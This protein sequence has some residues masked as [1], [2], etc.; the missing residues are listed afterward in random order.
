M[1]SAPASNASQVEDDDLP[2][3]GREQLCE[4]ARERLDLTSSQVSGELHQ[5][6]A[7]EDEEAQLFPEP[8]FIPSIIVSQSLGS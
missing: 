1:I 6:E 2:H 3:W 4:M 5:H 8:L 7:N